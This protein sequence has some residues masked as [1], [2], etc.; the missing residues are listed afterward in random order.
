VG[1]RRASSSSFCGL[2]GDELEPPGIEF[3]HY[4]VRFLCLSLSVLLRGPVHLYVFFLFLPRCV[5]LKIISSFFHRQ[6]LLLD[7]VS[8]L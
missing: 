3:V 7:L 1:Q 4:V 5:C 2:G 8:S 6:A